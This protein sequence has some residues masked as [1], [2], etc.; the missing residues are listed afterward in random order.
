MQQTGWD[1]NAISRAKKKKKSGRRKKKL[2]V[3]FPLPCLKTREVE[4]RATII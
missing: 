2:I 1:K 3:F 4:T